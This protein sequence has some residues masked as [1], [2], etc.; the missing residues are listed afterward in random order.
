MY[1][2]GEASSTFLDGFFDIFSR[3]YYRYYDSIQKHFRINFM[4]NSQMQRSLVC[5][6]WEIHLT[7]LTDDIEHTQRIGLEDPTVDSLRHINV[8]RRHVQQAAKDI[9]KCLEL[10]EPDSHT[11]E[12]EP[13]NEHLLESRGLEGKAAALKQDINDTTTL[14]I[15]AISVMDARASRIQARRSTALTALAAIYLPLSLATGVFGMNIRE[16][17]HGSPK[18]WA[19]VSLGLGLLVLS[20]PFLAWIFIDSGGPTQT[21]HHSSLTTGYDT[22][23]LERGLAVSSDASQRSDKEKSN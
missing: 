4:P 9:E 2:I 23:R 16:I 8:Q 15:G 7:H 6:A 1:H 13:Y 22:S 21:G 11:L 5:Y 3:F 20:G 12:Q 18:W 19:A 17:N 14:L 10:F